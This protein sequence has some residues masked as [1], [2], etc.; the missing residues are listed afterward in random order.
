MEV[1]YPASEKTA[2]HPIAIFKEGFGLWARNFLSLG[3]ICF[4]LYLPVIVL[5]MLFPDPKVWGLK[6]G[7]AKNSLSDILIALFAFLVGSWAFVVVSLAVDKLMRGEKAGIWENII[8]ARKR[9]FPYLGTLLLSGL[10]FFSVAAIFAC[11]AKA[12][13]LLVSAELKKRFSGG[14]IIPLFLQIARLLPPF[15][16][17]LGV[18]ATVYF[19]IRLSLGGIVSVVDDTAGPLTALKRSHALIKRYVTPVVGAYALLFLIS[20]LFFLVMVFL[21][22][23]IK[24]L[25]VSG[26]WLNPFDSLLS[27]ILTPLWVS[28]MAALYKK[29]KEAVE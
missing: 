7:L 22:V 4:I 24:A 6:P 23:A 16:L 8:A 29:L 5:Q 13:T 18:C 10:V 28:A 17:I 26:V 19:A 27:I 20:F 15:L 21:G 25:K 3:G 1:I 9:F 12:V 14:E 11:G 2:I